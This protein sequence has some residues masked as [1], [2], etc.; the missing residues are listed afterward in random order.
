M[1]LPGYYDP[2]ATQ[3]AASKRPYGGLSSKLWRD[4][5]E[6]VVANNP[7]DNYARMFSGADLAD[8]I[9][10][11]ASGTNDY[12][13]CTEVN[14]G[15]T[16]LKN[17]IAGAT[18]PVLEM[19]TASTTDLDGHQ[20]QFNKMGVTPTD[21]WDIYFEARIAQ[22][23]IGG[24]TVSSSAELF[25]GLASSDA[26]IMAGTTP[27]ATDWIGF[28]T[29]LADGA[30]TFGVGDATTRSVTSSAV[31]TLVDLD[32]AAAV[33][34]VPYAW[35]KVGF[36]LRGTADSGEYYVNGVRGEQ[37]VTWTSAP[38]AVVYP[39]FVCQSNATTDPITYINWFKIAQIRSGH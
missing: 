39:S 30:L 22:T 2:T 37:S 31:H 12:V 17:A 7:D 28:Y 26:T 34:Q 14:N 20:I 18:G 4:V 33:A 25:A 38:D 36:V 16:G 10:L 27:T 29:A 23:D 35:V 24:T 21:G 9:A 3:V 11:T 19:D 6:T 8:F 15:T 13:T 1:P 5:P 32:Q